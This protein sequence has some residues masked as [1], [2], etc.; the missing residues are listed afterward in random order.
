MIQP[1]A[2]HRLGEAVFMHYTWGSIFN[3]GGKEIWRFDKR[4]FY[5]PKHE[6]HVRALPQPSP[7]QP[8]SCG[9]T[10]TRE[11]GRAAAWPG[12]PGG[13]GTWERTAGL[14]L[15]VEMQGREFSVARSSSS[16]SD[17]PNAPSPAQQPTQTAAPEHHARELGP[18]LA[19]AGEDGA[20]S[21]AHHPDATQ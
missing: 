16:S 12:C 17:R 15:R 10:G 4:D 8:N 13:G 1:P 18:L 9:R 19:A 2:D 6:T 21:G 11:P 14:S 20:A 5:D 3:E 7:A